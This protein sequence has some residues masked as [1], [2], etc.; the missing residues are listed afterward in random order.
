[1]MRKQQQYR[2]SDYKCT[3]IDFKR[4][5]DAHLQTT[6]RQR[7]LNRAGCREH[8]KEVVM[9]RKP[10][11]VLAIALVLGTSGLSTSALARGADHGGGGGG[12]GFRDNHFGDGFGGTHG[13]RYGGYDNGASRLRG[14][15]RGY[16]GRDVWG[17]WGAYYGP[18]I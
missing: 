8:L 4:R 12:D 16:E 13:Y 2:T 9:L 15:F 1:M 14:G 7:I 3:F 17:H 18:M 6:D 5:A 11:V 10:L